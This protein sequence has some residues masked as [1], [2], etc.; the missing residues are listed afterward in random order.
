MRIWI[1][2]YFDLPFEWTSTYL[3]IAGSCNGILCLVDDNRS[4]PNHFYLWNPSIRKFVNLPTPMYTFETCSI[5]AHVQGFGFDCV[6]ND[7]KVESLCLVDSNYN[8]SKPIEIWMMR[9]YGAADTW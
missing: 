4:Y 3:N 5:C 8:Q 1:N 9:E 6:T 7:Y 2:V